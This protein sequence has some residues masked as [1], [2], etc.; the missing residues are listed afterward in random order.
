[1]PLFDGPVYQ[2]PDPFGL[3]GKGGVA[4]KSTDV[5]LS[6]GEDDDFV[7]TGPPKTAHDTVFEGT[8]FGTEQP[9]EYQQA[10]GGDTVDAPGAGVINAVRDPLGAAR[11]TAG[12][13]GRVATGRFDPNEQPEERNRNVGRGVLALI[14]GLVVV[15][16]VGQL[17]DI[18]VGDG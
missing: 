1:M 13:L 14:V 10:T 4:D 2:G 12:D 3:G 17:F 8:I 6:E 18:Q 9:E 11:Q 15:Y 5:V 7:V 16:T